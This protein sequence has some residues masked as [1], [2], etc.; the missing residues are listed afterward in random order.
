MLS[1]LPT[2]G[3]KLAQSPLSLY[4]YEFLK[5]ASAYTDLMTDD[6]FDKIHDIIYAK[7]LQLETIDSDDTEDELQ[8]LQI[9]S[10]M[11]EYLD[12]DITM[13]NMTGSW[14]DETNVTS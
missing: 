6:L 2:K 14:K 13:N 7:V 10:N 1:N 12:Y 5:V 3:R 9:L 11:L 4:D 8:C